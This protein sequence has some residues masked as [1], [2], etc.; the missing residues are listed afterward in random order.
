MIAINSAGVQ[1][2]TVFAYNIC[3]ALGVRFGWESMFYCFGTLGMIYVIPWLVLVHDS[4]ESHPCI[5]AEEKS[6]IISSIGAPAMGVKSSRVPWRKVA[7]SRP[8]YALMVMC[9]ASDWGFYTLLSDLPL[10]LR[11]NMHYS[12]SS[13]AGLSSV[14]Y[15]VML[16]V[17]LLLC[18][19]SDIVVRR[20]IISVT[21][22]RKLTTMSGSILPGLALIGIPYVR[23]NKDAVIAL[24]A[25]SIGTHV[26]HS[27]G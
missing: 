14:P 12:L 2:G 26:H 17:V 19:L 24:L 18:P 1:A 25:L 23:C 20:N 22:F 10:Y 27:N 9:W 16:V 7:T 15:A 8:F 3:G 11:D 13:N 21:N 6:Y 5:S 4:P